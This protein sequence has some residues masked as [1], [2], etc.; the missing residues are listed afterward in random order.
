MKRYGC[1]A[2]CLIVKTYQEF[3][4]LGTV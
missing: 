2:D 4:Q 1:Q 3:N